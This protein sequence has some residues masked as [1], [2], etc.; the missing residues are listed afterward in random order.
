MTDPNRDQ[1]RT[2]SPVEEAKERRPYVPPRV[3]RGRSVEV[4]T[5]GGG[6]PSGGP[7]P[8]RLSPRGGR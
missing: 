3:T 1:A 6:L 7:A 4:L 8:R 5:L 2:P